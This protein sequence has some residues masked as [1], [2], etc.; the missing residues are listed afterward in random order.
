L[1]KRYSKILATSSYYPEKVVTN[2]EI[3]DRAD[4][5]ITDRAVRKTIGVKRRRMAAQ[6]IVDSDLLT[7]AAKG[8]LMK[9]EMKP[10]KLSLLI[11]TKFLGDRLLP[12]TATF[13]QKK[14]GSRKA[15]QCYDIEGGMNSFITALDMG[16]RCINGGASYVLIVSGG[17]AHCLTN[18]TDPR[19]AFLFGD[20]A[21]AIL[22]G[23]ADSPHFPASYAYTNCAYYYHAFGTGIVDKFP[24]DLYEKQDFSILYHLYQMR[25]WKESADFYLQAANITKDRLL[26]ESGLSLEDINWVLVTENNKRLR[27]MTLESLGIPQD[28]SLSMIADYGNTMSAMLPG[29]LNKGFEAGDFTKGMNIMLLSHG[30]GA[31]GGGVLYRV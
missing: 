11:V 23:P 28:Q 24:S 8:C 29:L 10:E 14:L 6:G 1:I 27:D 22:L 30:E 13:V 15:F 12:M 19:T 9:A 16:T 31:E 5:P 7:E 3:I 2:Q 26:E 20:G 21:A 4:L 17:L 25:N 18:E